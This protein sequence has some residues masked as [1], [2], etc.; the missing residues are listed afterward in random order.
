MRTNLLELQYGTAIYAMKYVL[1]KCV[2]VG[3][4]CSIKEVV[5]LMNLETEK[6]R[7]I[8]TSWPLKRELL[9]ESRVCFV[10]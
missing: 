3:G 8:A 5:L 7:L 9:I 4:L 6:R 1:T 2:V 10:N